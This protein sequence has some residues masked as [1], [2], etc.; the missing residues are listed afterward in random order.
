M[1][2]TE[3][4]VEEYWKERFDGNALKFESDEAVS[5]WS[6]HSMRRMI[7]VFLREFNLSTDGGSLQVLDVG[8]GPGTYARILLELKHDVVGIDYSRSMVRKAVEKSN[9][10]G[11]RRYIVGDAYNLPFR[12]EAEFDAVILL[13]LLQHISDSGKVFAEAGGNIRN[14][15]GLFLI[16]LN[17][18]SFWNIIHGVISGFRKKKYDLKRYNP[19][20]LKKTLEDLEYGGVEVKGIYILPKILAPLEDRIDEAGFFR[21]LDSLPIIPALMSH[22]FLIK[23]VKETFSE[24]VSSKT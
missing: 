13:G 15:G 6:A 12:K 10:G 23:A 7:E 8:C 21:I 9:E 11:N 17:S 3:V 16:T 14:G 18:L 19:Y 24:K 4:S 20:K 22:S 2:T 1:Q 5:G